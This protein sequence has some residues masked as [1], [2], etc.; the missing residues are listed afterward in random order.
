M[1]KIEMAEYR[2]WVRLKQ[3]CMNEKNDRFSSYGGRGIKVCQ[4]WVDSF[5]R[6]FSDMGPRPSSDH[7]VDRIDN[8]GDYSPENCRWAT[9]SQQQK[10][11]RKFKQPGNQGG[12]H[13]THK[14][15]EKARVIAVANITKA[16][17]AKEMNPNSK[18][19]ADVAE[20][21]RSEYEKDK[22]IRMADLGF[23]FGVGRETARKVVRG[24]SW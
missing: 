18:I 14:N 12:N 2:A 1:R 11:K 15:P 21:I 5:E 17:G 20:R 6:F 13:W 8:D 10:N 22:S 9:R 3:R 23:M 19:T 4:E 16:H 7:S 24:L